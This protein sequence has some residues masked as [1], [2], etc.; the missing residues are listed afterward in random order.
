MSTDNL[1]PDLLFGTHCQFGSRIIF[2]LWTAR[3]EWECRQDLREKNERN[4]MFLCHGTI[5]HW[6]LAKAEDVGKCL[7][8]W[9]SAGFKRRMWEDCLRNYT[10]FSL[11]W[12]F[13]Q[14]ICPTQKIKNKIIAQLKINST[15]FQPTRTHKHP[16]R[17]KLEHSRF[18]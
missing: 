11:R 12:C 10:L 6:L 8:S 7:V 4:L 2:G 1:R 18:I 17:L 3:T 9:K 14:K 16:C 15:K 13:T 5:C